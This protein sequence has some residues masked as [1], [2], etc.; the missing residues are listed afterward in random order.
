[1]RLYVAEGSVL[2]ERALRNLEAVCE[3]FVPGKYQLEIIDLAKEPGRAVEDDIIAIPTLVRLAPGPKRRVVGVLDMAKLAA[4]LN[5]PAV[6][7]KLG[8]DGAGG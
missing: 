6:E 8:L 4:A 5:L 1:M 7:E 2:A 3:K